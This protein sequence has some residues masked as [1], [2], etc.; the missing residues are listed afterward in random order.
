[1]YL[2]PALQYNGLTLAA[3]HAHL[4]R[5]KGLNLTHFD[6]VAGH[7]VAT[8]KELGVAQ[9]LIDEVSCCRGG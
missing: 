2:L 1:V 7:L 8:L 3:S 9:E 5:D 6:A 4:M